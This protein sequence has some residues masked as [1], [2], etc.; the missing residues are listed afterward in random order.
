MSLWDMINVD[1]QAINR[2]IKVTMDL[3]N[4]IDQLGEI[5]TLRERLCSM[6]LRIAECQCVIFMVSNF[7]F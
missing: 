3:K 6:D 1:C 7:N 4:Y 2:L 5:E